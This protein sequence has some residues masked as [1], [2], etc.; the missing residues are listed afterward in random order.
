MRIGRPQPIEIRFVGGLDRVAFAFLAPA[1][2]VE[3]GENN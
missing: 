1:E 2:A 3:D